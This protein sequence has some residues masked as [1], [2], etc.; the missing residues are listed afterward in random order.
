MPLSLKTLILWSSKQKHCYVILWCPYAYYISKDNNN[1]CFSDQQQITE[2]CYGI[3]VNKVCFC[4][5]TSD[6]ILALC[7]KLNSDFTAVSSVLNLQFMLWGLKLYTFITYSM[8][9]LYFSVPNKVKRMA[10]LV[11]FKLF[12]Y[13]TAL[14][15]GCITTHL[16]WNY[17]YHVYLNNYLYLNTKQYISMN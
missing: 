13:S 11:N 10:L 9:V 6:I 3:Q 16:T 4:I 15:T 8:S 2:A 12:Q 7:N 14:D 1:K 5:H 17:Y